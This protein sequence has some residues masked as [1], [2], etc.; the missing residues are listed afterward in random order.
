MSG[1]FITLEGGEGVGK[2]TLAAALLGRLEAAG[3]QVELTREPGGTPLA[4]AVRDLALQP[5]GGESWSPLALA[6]L[7]NAARLD[8]LER[9]IR[10]ALAAGRVVLC[11]RFGDSTRVYQSVEDGTAPA[12]LDALDDW[13]VGETQ[14]DLT[15]L[16]DADPEA[17]LG[18]RADRAGPRDAF[19][20]RDLAFHRAIRAGFLA[21]AARFP[22]RIVVLD[23]TR[24]ATEVAGAA[25]A[26]VSARLGL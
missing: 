9:R 20:A 3:L 13:V 10:P 7:M 16:L 19:E 23:A 6:L 1:R 14:P 12:A 21:L 15:L 26:V 18:R 4:E 5:P 17:V 2:S 24:P 22:E 8:H 11:D 25:W